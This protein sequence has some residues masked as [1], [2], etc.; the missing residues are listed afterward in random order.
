MYVAPTFQ[1]LK[2]IWMCIGDLR[3]CL[4]FE[5]SMLNVRCEILADVQ[6][7][8]NWFTVKSETCPYVLTKHHAIK[9]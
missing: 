4:R 3:I 6:L 7:C 1:M 5:T 8:E 2:P 9:D